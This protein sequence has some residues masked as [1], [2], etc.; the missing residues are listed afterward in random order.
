[1][2]YLFISL[3]IF[4]TI[5]QP[6]YAITLPEINNLND[7]ALS[8]EPRYPKPGDAVTASVQ[9][10][11]HNLQGMDIKWSVDGVVLGSGTGLTTTIFKA[12]ELGKSLDLSVEVVGLTT[13]Q[14]VVAPIM[15]DILWEAQTYTHPGY[16]GRALPVDNSWIRALALPHLGNDS[17]ID[18][19]KLIYNWYKDGRFLIKDSGINRSSITTKSPGIYSKYNLNVEVTDLNGT[20]LGRS[21]VTI[22][23]TEPEL[24]LYE[25]S[26]LIGTI[27][28]RALLGS[29][30]STYTKESD[31]VAVPYYFSILNPSTLRYKWQSYN[32]RITQD[33]EP[34]IITILESVTGAALSVSARHKDVLLQSAK[35]R[36]SISEKSLVGGGSGQEGYLSPFGSPDDI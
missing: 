35:A 14:R 28:Y 36:Y 17:N 25:S 34:Q 23:S 7:V 31:V 22:L 21:G 20:P 5:A 15:V 29:T 3:A 1:M 32:M 30:P 9:S 10:Y 27:F 8:I 18:T 4:V 19:T 16:L 33:S 11:S 12:P 13:L 2:R 26:P 6:V 24:I